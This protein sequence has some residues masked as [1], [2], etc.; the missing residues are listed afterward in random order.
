VTALSAVKLAQ[1][2]VD[3]AAPDDEGTD[4]HSR[5]QIIIQA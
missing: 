4:T 1:P 2:L 5:N 3:K